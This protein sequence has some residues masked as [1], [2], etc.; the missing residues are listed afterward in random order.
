[1]SKKRSKKPR[2]K[3]MKRLSRL[4]AAKHWIPKY[5]GKNIVRGYKKRFN[6]DLLCA[7]TELGMLG[8]KVDS[9]YV[10]QLKIEKENRRKINERKKM[11]KQ[12][13]EQ[14]E[15]YPDS[16][17]YFY[18]IA[19]YTDNGFPYG[20]T[21]EEYYLSKF[22]YIAGYKDNGEP[23]GITWE[24]FELSMPIEESNEKLDNCSIKES[25][26]LFDE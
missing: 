17:E 3:S 7:A 2:R 16:D 15:L 19:G 6:V 5:D 11:K 1:M 20:I 22:Y 24:D 13:E 4:Q 12:E 14:F 8:I 18:F 10:E 25:K 23:Y 9:K 26:T 21:W